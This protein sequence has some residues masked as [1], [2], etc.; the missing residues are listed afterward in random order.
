M[1]RGDWAVLPVKASKPLRMRGSRERGLAT[2]DQG[3]RCGVHT[4]RD[5]SREERGA[6]PMGSSR[7]KRAPGKMVQD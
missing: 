6:R 5:G 1:S 4:P 3:K 7:R 2:R